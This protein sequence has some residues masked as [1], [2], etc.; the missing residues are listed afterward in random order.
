MDTVEAVGEQLQYLAAQLVALPTG[1]PGVPEDRRVSRL[2]AELQREQHRL[3]AIWGRALALRSDLEAAEELGLSALLEGEEPRPFLDEARDLHEQFRAHLVVVLLA[4]VPRSSSVSLLLQ[5]PD[6]GRAFDCWLLPLLE[7][8][9]R[10]G[11]TLQGHLDGD[12]DSA[13]GWPEALR[14]GPPRGGRELLERLE[15]PERSTR[16]VILRCSGE[17]AGGLLALEAGLHR[18]R[19]E[20]PDE[21]LVHLLC[22]RIAMRAE[23]AR[24]ELARPELQPALPGPA[25]ALRA[26]IAVREHDPVEG[27]L[28]VL[29]RRRRLDLRAED[30]WPRFEQIAL[31]HLLVFEEDPELDRDDLFKG[32]L[33]G[34]PRGAPRG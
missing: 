5:E 17:R 18:W 16:N 28:H 19:P 22:V 15:A 24:E 8:A 1:R 27:Q 11:W 26:A 21:P 9:P 13:G 20:R 10:R 12:C 25:A 29:G 2:R 30:Y 23:L 31:E 3:S 7:D 33:D 32:V 4:Q 14:W 6:A 34:L